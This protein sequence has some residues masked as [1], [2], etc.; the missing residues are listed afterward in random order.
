MEGIKELSLLLVHANTDFFTST[1]LFMFSIKAGL[2]CDYPD[3]C[4]NL[5]IDNIIK[6][7]I[8]WVSR[9]PKPWNHMERVWN[10]L[11]KKSSLRSVIDGYKIQ[12]NKAIPQLTDILEL[13]GCIVTMDALDSHFS[14]STS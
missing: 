5:N 14:R 12:R 2:S 11:S 7:S 13:K 3:Q 8:N 10:C 9:S 1:L 6:I 4:I